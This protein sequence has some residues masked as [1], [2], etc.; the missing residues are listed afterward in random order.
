MLAMAHSLHTKSEPKLVSSSVRWSCESGS[1]NHI[2]SFTGLGSSRQSKK[3]LSRIKSAIPK[4]KSRTSYRISDAA[5][6][7]NSNI[8]EPYRLH[9]RAMLRLV[10]RSK[11]TVLTAL[12]KMSP[13]SLLLMIESIPQTPHTET[14]T[15]SGTMTKW[16]RQRRTQSFTNPPRLACILREHHQ[17]LLSL[18]LFPSLRG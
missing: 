8:R 15:R 16:L 17:A 6:S 13:L 14:V 10:S 1:T 11:K 3:T 2:Y 9:Q 4:P 7:N 5:R 12:Q 18:P